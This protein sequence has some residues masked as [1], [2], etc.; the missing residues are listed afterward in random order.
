MK[1]QRR[2][3]A[4]MFTD[5][6]N[7]TKLMGEDE[8]KA[9]GYLRLN[10]EIQKPLID[11]YAGTFIKELGDGILSSF[12]TVT[13]SVFCAIEIQ[14]RCNEQNDFKLR[15]GIHSGE[16]IFE[17][18]DVFGDGVNIASRLQAYAPI[19]GICISETVNNN[20]TN[21]KEI[22]TRFLR[23]EN[24]KNVQQ[25][26]KIYEVILKDTQDAYENTST[27]KIA[28]QKSIAILPFV[29]MSAD[30]EQEYFSD[31]M[32]EE[33]LNSLS[34]LK[35]L[36]VAGRASSFQF[37]G[38][39]IDLNEVGKKLNVRTV[40]E[41]SVRKQKNRLRI[42]AQLTN[43]DDGYNLW[44]EKYDRE[45][46]DI[47]AIQ[48]EIALAIT[49]KL[50]ITLLQKEK[51]RINKK[52]TQNKEAYELYLK[53]RFYMNRRGASIW[54]GMKYF[55]EAMAKD[56]NFA[57]AYAGYA[58]AC[59]LLAFYNFLPTGEV[60]PKAKFAAEYALKIDN[61]LSE[62]HTSLGFYYGY[63]EW[64]KKRS[65]EYF[66][67][68]LELNPNYAQ[69]HFWYA[70]FYLAWI[71]NDFVK[72]EEQMKY[73]IELEPLSAIGYA[74]Q[75]CM[76][77]TENKHKE[78]VQAAKTGVELDAGSYLSHRMMGSSYVELGE[79]DE[80][81][82]IFK[83]CIEISKRFQWS[84]TD[85]L[86]AYC[87][88]GNKEEAI[89]LLEELKKRAATENICYA[90]LG[91]SEAWLGNI[92]TAMEYIQKAFDNREPIL[93]TFKIKDVPGM[94]DTLRKDPRFQQLVEKIAFSE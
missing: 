78:A 55:Q 14:K 53:G 5:I 67:K 41:G 32:A 4:I 69:G 17:D 44:S 46:D 61:T 54:Q 18:N 25:P 81:I 22:K 29:N 74:I 83:Y 93:I 24:L 63:F 47:F 51:E 34:H 40:L 70:L 23:E 30:P 76:F 21:Q 75:T 64:D 52:P 1:Q 9:F 77:Y 80:A 33:I 92:N 86:W 62:A 43:V 84:I 59:L 39:N 90:Y 49:K 89:I 65:G 79:L 73:A 57:L 12:Q 31:G 8:H 50:K 71:E 60:M 37:K 48:D 19:G 66:K 72:A 82:R 20:I 58:D 91:L 2:L 56:E 3:A 88:N 11:K 87:R 45:I 94:P 35:E 28:P 7:Y 27:M 36:K 42:T 85:L 10:R 38:K 13:D 16:V 26:V 15:I 68:A 6:V